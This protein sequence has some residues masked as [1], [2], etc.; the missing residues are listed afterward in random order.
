MHNAAQDVIQ[1][2][3]LNALSIG[4]LFL[5]GFIGGLVSGFI[6]SGEPSF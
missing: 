6:G 1:F 5:V 4:F 3:D 2:I